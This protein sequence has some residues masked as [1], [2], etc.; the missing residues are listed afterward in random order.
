MKAFLENIRKAN[1]LSQQLGRET[2]F[3]PKADFVLSDA[4]TTQSFRLQLE[5]LE[6]MNLV[7]LQYVNQSLVSFID[8]Q[9]FN[10]IVQKM[11]G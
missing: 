9:T 11:Q 4:T 5:R 10:D 1:T 3:V 7:A 6:R 8:E 2:H